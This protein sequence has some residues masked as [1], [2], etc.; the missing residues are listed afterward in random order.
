MGK[1]VKVSAIQIQYPDGDVKQL[2]VEDARELYKQLDDLFGKVY[3]QPQQPIII[4][5]R[6]WPRWTSPPVTID[7]PKPLAPQIWCCTDAST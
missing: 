1:K 3:V 4:E 5:R 7:A 6:E 2:T